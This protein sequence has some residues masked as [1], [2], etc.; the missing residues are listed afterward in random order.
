M[1]H[2]SDI[3]LAGKKQAML[4]GRGRFRNYSVDIDRAEVADEILAVRVEMYRAEMPLGFVWSALATFC[5]RNVLPFRTC[6][7]PLLPEAVAFSLPLSV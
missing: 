4:F 5:E 1:A 6:G 3:K 2:D 7:A